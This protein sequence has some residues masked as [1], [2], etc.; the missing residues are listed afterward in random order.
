M[1]SHE[2][3]VNEILRHFATVRMIAFL[4]PVRSCKTKYLALVALM[5]TVNLPKTKAQDFAKTKSMNIS[6]ALDNF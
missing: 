2:E 5:G 6:I 1:R 3:H 4:R